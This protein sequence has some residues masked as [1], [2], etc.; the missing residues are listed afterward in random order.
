MASSPVRRFFRANFYK[1]SSFCWLINFTRR[2]V[3]LLHFW[4]IS[5]STTLRY[6][7]LHSV[8]DVYSTVLYVR[9]MCWCEV[10]PNSST[11]CL[12]SSIKASL[13]NN[14]IRRTTGPSFL[15][16]AFVRDAPFSSSGVNN[17]VHPHLV[18]PWLGSFPVESLAFAANCKLQSNQLITRFQPWP[19]PY[20]TIH[21]VLVCFW[22][23]LL[24]KSSCYFFWDSTVFD[25]RRLAP[26]L[27]LAQSK[28]YF[29]NVR[30]EHNSN[31][32]DY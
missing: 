13:P 32:N 7:V 4:R 28:L 6:P 12:S 18:R 19:Q 14:L 10:Y 30:Y 17:A 27:A 2:S 15:S 24:L 20:C 22:P 23:I 5:A 11:P 8:G 25:E 31:T 29:G 16:L 21:T 1:S 26:F 3:K 9:Q